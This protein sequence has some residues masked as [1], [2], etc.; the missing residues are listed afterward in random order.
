VGN[1]YETHPQHF[2]WV[3]TGPD[4]PVCV[5]TDFSIGDVAQCRGQVK[6]AWLVESPG[7]FPRPYEKIREIE[8][9]F[10]YIFT[11]NAALLDRGP[12]YQ[13]APL[14]GCWIREPKIHPKT[15]L[16]SIIASEKGK[17]EGQALRQRI[18][19]TIDGVDKYGRGCGRTIITKDEGLRDYRYSIAVENCRNDY[20]FTE[21]LID[22]FATGT[23]PIYW[24]AQYV[25]SVFD[26]RGI[27]TFNDITEL[28]GIIN[29]LSASDYTERYRAVERNFLISEL[30]RVTEDYLW[31]IHLRKMVNGL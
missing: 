16:V 21:K 11:F 1:C 31:D 6:I 3:R 20:Y 26:K 17:T 23:I 25:N 15:R 9:A 8:D 12:K 24:G 29:G 2:R 14:G 22:C 18:L 10:D 4:L 28:P 7:V 30:Y 19:E 27:I 13:F 5:F